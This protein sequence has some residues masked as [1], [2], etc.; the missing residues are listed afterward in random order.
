MIP[1]LL[2]IISVTAIL[3]FGQLTSPSNSAYI[4][5]SH[6]ISLEKRYEVKSVSEVFKDNILLNLAYLR[7]VVH[8]SKDIKWDE[9]RN[10]FHYEFKLEPNKTFTFHDDVL[11]EYKE[12]V[13]LTTNAHFNA[14]EGFKTDGY[15]FGDG[16]CHL[17]SL[18]YWV[19]KDAYLDSYAPTDHD[20]MA[21]PEIER[22]YGVSIYSSP[23][24]KGSNSQQNL[25]ITNNR[26]AVIKFVFDYNGEK[27]RVTVVEDNGVSN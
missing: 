26:A 4:L 9:V 1:S 2:T 13:V 20:F 23:Y 8:S 22:Q 24:S 17:A 25:Y 21:I 16:V 6:E 15:L 18:M 3:N 10:P 19:A 11:A 5:S 12:R 27:L 7:G 14:A